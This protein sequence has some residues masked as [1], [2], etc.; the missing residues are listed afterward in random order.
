MTYSTDACFASRLGDSDSPSF[1]WGTF[2]VGVRSL[3]LCKTASQARADAVEKLE[4]AG[5][6][7]WEGKLATLS[8][9]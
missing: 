3:H 5:F 7:T 8:E 9:A 6:F 2:G 4:V 1:D